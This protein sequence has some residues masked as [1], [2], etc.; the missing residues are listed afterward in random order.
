MI[1]R[2]ICFAAICFCS[3]CAGKAHANIGLDGQWEGIAHGPELQIVMRVAG[4]PG[5]Y[6]V[7]TDSTFQHA[8][9]LPTDISLD[10]SGNVSFTIHVPTPFTFT[11]QLV[12]HAITGTWYQKGLN[13]PLTLSSD[14]SDDFPTPQPNAS[15]AWYGI[16]AGVGYRV[17]VHI[18]GVPGE[19]VA[20]VD[21]PDQH[22]TGMK[23]TA[24]VDPIGN[25][26]IVIPGNNPPLKITAF[27]N[28]NTITGTWVQNGMGPIVLARR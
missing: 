9:G 11:G 5:E 1:F 20:S 12:G 21:S 16:L 13:G 23:A 14:A 4:M 3:L 19:Y 24:N 2:T 17:V 6:T 27:L 28:G 7:T 10:S 26:F 18:G 8:Y 22:V 15:G 25:V